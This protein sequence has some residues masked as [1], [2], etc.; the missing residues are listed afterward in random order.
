MRYAGLVLFAV[1]LSQQ[2]AAGELSQEE[3]CTKLGEVA[4]QA[5]RSRLEGLNMN[6][7]IDAALIDHDAE[8]LGIS[9]KRVMAA[10][11]ISYMAKMKPESMREYYI[12][13]CKKDILR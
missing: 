9:E 12:S 5:S 10:V 2:S 1:L 4:E 3:Q 8:K 13:Q 6:R 11:R 7:A